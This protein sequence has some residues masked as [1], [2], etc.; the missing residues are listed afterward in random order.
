MRWRRASTVTVVFVALLTISSRVQ[1]QYQMESLSRGVIA[2]RSSNTQV[3][4]GWRLFATDP[5]SVSFN[6]YRSANGAAAVKLNNSSIIDS[7][8]YVD[9]TASLTVPNAYHVTAVIGGIEGAPSTS[10]TLPANSAAQP[11]FTIPMPPIADGTYY[12]H[13][14]WAGDLDGDGYMDIIVDRLPVTGTTIKL[15]AYSTRTRARLW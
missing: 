1:A 5:E 3:Y 8:N 7:T 13:L 6:V 10:W 4:V 11:C 15:E 2:V 12:V 14:A 9:T